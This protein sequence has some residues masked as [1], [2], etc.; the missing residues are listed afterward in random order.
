MLEQEATKRPLHIAGIGPRRMS[1]HFGA[2]VA[3][4]E[5]PRKGISLVV[6]RLPKSSQ[7]AKR[8]TVED[9][10]RA[11]LELRD[12]HPTDTRTKLKLR[13][14][15][16]VKRLRLE[17]PDWL[18]ANL[19]PKLSRKGGQD[20]STRD[21]ALRNSVLAE[22]EEMRRALPPQRVSARQLLIKLADEGLRARAHRSRKYPKTIAAL[23][24]VDEPI[25]RFQLRR[26]R[27]AITQLIEEGRPIRSSYVRTKAGL[28][29]RHNHIAAKAISEWQAGG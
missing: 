1:A 11:W 2:S 19:P 21:I 8:R 9:L 22:A 16:L 14:H 5:M 6:R 17:D 10:R 23:K 27:W 28:Q 3:D 4:D 20:T 24:K 26:A 29:T 13:K 7:P 12:A 18:E 25:E 15:R